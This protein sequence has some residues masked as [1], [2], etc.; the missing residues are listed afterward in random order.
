MGTGVTTRPL[1]PVPV[2]G[3][4]VMIYC[5]GRGSPWALSRA[6]SGWHTKATAP[7]GGAAQAGRMGCRAQ[8]ILLLPGSLVWRFGNHSLCLYPHGLHG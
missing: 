3:P 1:Q 2:L 5:P 7:G 8:P 4:S 6:P